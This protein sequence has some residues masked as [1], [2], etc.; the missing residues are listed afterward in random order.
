MNRV[1]FLAA[2]GIFL[3]LI[4]IGAWQFLPRTAEAPPVTNQSQLPYI[5]T[6]TTSSTKP[7]IQVQP[8]EPANT[9][10][11]HPLPL[12]K[13]ESVASWNFKGAYADNPELTAKARNEVQRLSGL[14]GEGTY[15]DTI[16][17]VSIANQYG[18]LGDGEREY[19]YLGRAIRSDTETTGLPWHNL[20]VLM[21]RLGALKTARTAYEKSTLIQPGLSF[22]HYAYLE[23]LT[24][25][26]K[27]DTATIEGAFSA[28]ENNI[29]KTSYLLELRA[30]WEKS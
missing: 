7:N 6:N 23:F 5:D 1:H 24:A 29:G 2:V 4:G 14:I 25:R 15:S 28:A 21:E 20:G 18:L 27:D 11:F 17:Y 3:A 9:S 12:V 10:V 30:E 26:M 19:D 22:Y 8:T 16:L 13:G